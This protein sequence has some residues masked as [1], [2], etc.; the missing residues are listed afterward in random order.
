MYMLYMYHASPRM[1]RGEIMDFLRAARNPFKTTIMCICGE[2]FRWIY[3][4]CFVHIF[5]EK[6]KFNGCFFARLKGL[7][8]F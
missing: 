1:S 5:F 8:F 6:D 4:A 7:K 2:A 3:I